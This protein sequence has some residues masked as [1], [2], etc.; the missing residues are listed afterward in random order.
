[1]RTILEMLVLL[2]VIFSLLIGEVEWGC[3]GYL[4]FCQ[5]VNSERLKKLEGGGK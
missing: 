3:I 1:M 5:L 2:G 4:I